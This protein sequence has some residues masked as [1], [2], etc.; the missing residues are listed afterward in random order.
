MEQFTPG[1]WFVAA[2]IPGMKG[3]DQVMDR[4]IHTKDG[5]HV[6]EVFQYQNHEN[7]NGPSLANAR[8]ISK[9]PELLA[10]LLAYVELEESSAPTSSSPMRERARAIIAEVKGE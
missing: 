5:R 1:P 2:P 8:L 9:A 3:C 6:A 10:C 4:L 7:K